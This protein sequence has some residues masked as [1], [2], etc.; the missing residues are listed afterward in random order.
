V[1][2]EEAQDLTEALYTALIG[3]APRAHLRSSGAPWW[4]ETT[5]AAVK[6]FY[7]ARRSGPAEEE[8]FALRAA[9]RKAKRAYWRSR[10]ENAEDLPSLYKIT[11]WQQ[12]S[13]QYTSPP[14][15]RADWSRH[16]YS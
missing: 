12:H 2:A 3:S 4:N 7:Q 13:L 9:V 8:K 14:A 16:L 1:T 5:A 6:D 15:S 10:V 11:R